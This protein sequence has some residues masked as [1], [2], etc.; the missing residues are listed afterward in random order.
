MARVRKWVVIGSSLALFFGA[1]F[2]FGVLSHFGDPVVRVEV[3]NRANKP[4]KIVR[5]THE[6]GTAIASNI[7]PGVTVSL[8]F[9]APGDTSF[10]TVVEFADGSHLEGAEQYAEA[11]YRITETVT[12]DGIAE[13][14]A[15][16]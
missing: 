4:I 11:G 8:K 2:V 14:I 1:G 7:G 15:L 13:R 3:T 10:R 5:V 9:F 16:Y 12:E 6:H